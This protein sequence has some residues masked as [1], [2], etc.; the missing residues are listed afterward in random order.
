MKID[1]TTNKPDPWVKFTKVLEYL[2][3]S[4]STGRRYVDKGLLPPPKYLNGYR[5]IRLSAVGKC[6][7]NLIKTEK[8]KPN[9]GQAYT[10]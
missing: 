4:D 5:V 9:N 3:I 10:R 6:E 7:K 1:P 8:P 2:G